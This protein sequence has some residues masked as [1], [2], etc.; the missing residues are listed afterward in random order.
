MEISLS[1]SLDQTLD[2]F[3][4]IDTQEESLNSNHIEKVNVLRERNK[5]IKNGFDRLQGLAAQGPDSKD[6]IEP[7]V[8]GL[9]KIALESKFSPEELESLRIELKHYENRL[10]K[11][12]HLQVEA[13]LSEE[14]HKEKQL[15][16]V[17]T[18]GL[19]QM[20]DDIKK[21]A[22]KVEKIHL[23]LETRIMQKHIEL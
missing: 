6:F 17:K 10:L 1:D 19:L 4:T 14:R 20:E 16:G 18:P 5:D 8:Q 9:W 3:N 22:R 23:D 2:K 7:K 13:A 21:H 11:L 15:S 12:R